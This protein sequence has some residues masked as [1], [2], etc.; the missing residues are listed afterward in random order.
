[1]PISSRITCRSDSISC[2]R[3]AGLPHDVGEDVERELELRV[4]NAHVEHRLLVRRERVHLAADRLDRLGD[5]ARRAIGGALEQ[6]MF[7]EVARA[8][9]ARRA[10]RARRSRPTCRASPS[11]GPAVASVTTRSPESSRVRRITRLTGAA[12]RRLRPL[13]RVAA[14][15]T[16]TITGRRGRRLVG[17]TEVAELL[18]RLLVPERLERRGLARRRPARRGSPLDRRDSPRSPR[19]PRSRRRS[20]RSARSRLAAAVAAAFGLVADA[21]TTRACRSGRCRRPSP[22]ARRRAR[23]RPRPGRCACPDR[24]WRCA[25]RPSRPGR[26]LTNA[27]NLV[28]FTTRPV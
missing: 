20:R 27:P 28:M 3:N 21:A 1:M 22:R 26:M 24:A 13:R 8:R 16:A 9:L 23:A 5:L 11:A 19:S 4:G 14:T 2:S 17:R 15:A 6:Q 10:R 12:R 7:E 18:A 25:R